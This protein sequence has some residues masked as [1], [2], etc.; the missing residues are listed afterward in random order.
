[1]Y[2]RLRFLRSAA[3][4]NHMTRNQRGYAV[5]SQAAIFEFGGGACLHIHAFSWGVTDMQ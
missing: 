2:W 4:E 1:M 3:V 5:A